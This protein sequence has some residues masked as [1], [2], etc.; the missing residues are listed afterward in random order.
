MDLKR[1][2][3]VVQR[4]HSSV[5]GGSESEALHY[6]ELLK[7]RYDLELLTTT[8]N[9]PVKWENVLEAGEERMDGFTVRR[10]P[11]SQGRAD[12]WHKLYAKVTDRYFEDI[13][14]K[15]LKIHERLI[16]WPLGLQEEFIYK[17][18]PYSIDLINYIKQ[19]EHLY[20]AFIFFT[21]L[22]P[23]TY[24]G[25]SCVPQR[26]I[27]FVPTLHDEPPAYLS[28]YQYMAR[29]AK[30]ILWNAQEEKDFAEKLWDISGG[31]VIGMGVKTKQCKKE[32]KEPYILYCGRIDVNK[33]CTQL[34]DYFLKFKKSD[35]SGF[36]L[37]FTG[38][39]Y[40]GLPQEDA[41]LFKGFVCEEE[42]LQ[43]MADAT[44]FVMP[45]V[46][47]SFSIVTLEAMAQNTPVIANRGSEVVA[48]HLKRSGGGLTYD[49]YKSFR[50]ALKYLSENEE[51]AA[52]MGR[53]GRKYVLANYSLEKVR[54]M[55]I[56]EIEKIGQY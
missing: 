43:L 51:K 6:A 26:K 52:E 2:A 16:H 30:T 47:E 13:Q 48:G 40:I 20:S 37:I 21:Y 56:E 25:M 24:F 4:S 38:T 3:I 42:K 32:K 53:M 12:Y 23:T 35:K 7:D 19:N 11:V 29:M 49:D 33:G 39:D 46:Y 22:Y 15:E 44:A 54:D 14:K 36:K 9:D 18:G 34:V 45:S 10:F 1:V 55:I 8:A 31:R 5:V 27:L 41:V 28:A 17:Q 50:D